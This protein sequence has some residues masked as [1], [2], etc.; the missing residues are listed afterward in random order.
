MKKYFVLILAA[1]MLVMPTVTY[2]AKTKAK[3]NKKE[4]TKTE[5]VEKLEF[6]A[7]PKVYMFRGEGCP[8][9]EEALEYFDGLKA[10]Y[11]FELIT[12]EVWYDEDNKALMN[13]VAAGLGETASGVPYIII[14]EKTFSGYAETYNTAIEEAIVAE[15]VNG[16]A[17]DKVKK[18]ITKEKEKSQATTIVLSVLVIAGIVALIVLGRKSAKQE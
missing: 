11:N 1:L 17:N 7:T 6:K 15:G 3:S 2:A 4:E 18:F 8:H 14:G 10:K 5:E 16:N 13:K 12:Y 9:C